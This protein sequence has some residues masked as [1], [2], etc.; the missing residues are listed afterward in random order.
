MSPRPFLGWRTLVTALAALVA[1]VTWVRAQ[2]RALFYAEPNFQGASLVVEAGASVPD[3]A[4]MR[5]NDGTRWTFSS[6]R[7]E[8][9]ARATVSSAPNFS[10]D[11]IEI[12]GD[13][14]DLFS[15]P[16]NGGAGTWDQSIAAIA[17]TGPGRP[18]AQPSPALPPP[19]AGGPSEVSVGIGI[20]VGP[21]RPAA[22]PR[23]DARTADLIVQRAYREVL[24]RAADP[25]GLR[26]YRQRL[27]FEG[28]SER[29]VIAHLQRSPEAR[30][31]SADAAITNAYR[32]VLGRDPD[33]NGLAHYRAKWREGWTQGQIRDDL[34]RSNESR[35]T[36]YRV[37][38]TRAFRDLLGREP[39]AAGYATYERLM[40]ERHYTE[41]DIRAAIM[42]SPEYR[43]RRSGR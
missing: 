26:T 24:D 28:W 7:L 30:A 35:N 17:V 39:D 20:G 37:V 31:V 14:A 4:T 18:S 34:R 2:S 32:E 40:R 33:A 9:G 36:Q 11:R 27:M 13:V 41:R 1:G 3:L 43:Q 16:R 38:I 42:D 8:G 5:R 22:R 23:Y 15:L 21:S 12:G 6:V 19:V 29:D 25:E 10:G